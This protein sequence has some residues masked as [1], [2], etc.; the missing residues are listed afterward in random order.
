MLL[1]LG[2]VAVLS[3]CHTDGA[4]DHDTQYQLSAERR[5]FKTAVPLPE[6]TPDGAGGTVLMQPGFVEDYLR[7]GRTAMRLSPASVTSDADARAL[8]LL[9]SWL[10]DR[11]VQTVVEPP[12][13]TRDAPE[14]GMVTLSFEAYV[15]KVPTCGDWSGT[16]GFNP[17]NRYHSNFACAYNRNIGLML[18]DPGD[19]I[20]GRPPGPADTARQGL[21]IEKY[22]LGETTATETPEEESGS[23]TGIAE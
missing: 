12:L 5:T 2:G 17:S 23:V 3:G 19:L 8:T 16:T 9:R 18:S 13:F 15:A 22:R 1:A 7:R 14:G 10:E 20:Q 6:V 4:P 11:G 21:V